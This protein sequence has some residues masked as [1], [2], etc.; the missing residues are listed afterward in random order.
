MQM[1]GDISKVKDIMMSN[2]KSWDSDKISSMFDSTTVR[3]IVNTPLLASVRT[4]K[5]VWK[6]E[7]DG[8]YTVRSAYNYYVNSVESQD[9][10]GIA[11]NWQQIWRAKIPPRV[12]NLLWRICRNVL[13]TR[14]RLNSRGI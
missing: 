9:N 1:S 13:P 5:L 4:D 7:Q 12:K 3:R 8:L 10:A 6:L 2:S 14:V 11:G